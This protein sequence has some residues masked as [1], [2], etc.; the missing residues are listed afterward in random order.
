MRLGAD[1]LFVGEVCCAEVGC[2]LLLAAEI[3]HGAAVDCLKV[4]LFVFCRD[5]RRMWR[6]E[7]AQTTSPTA[8]FLSKARPSIQIRSGMVRSF[9]PVNAVVIYVSAFVGADVGVKSRTKNANS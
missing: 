5:I 7:S 6:K 8:S 9:V 2:A 1:F 3:R 4:R